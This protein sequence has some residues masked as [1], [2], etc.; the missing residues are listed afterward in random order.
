M[1]ETDE[2]HDAE[3]RTILGRDT[4]DIVCRGDAARSRHVLRRD[5]RCAR[6]VPTQMAGGEPTVII[7]TATRARADVQIDR[8]WPRLVLRAHVGT[9][10]ENSAASDQEVCRQPMRRAHYHLHSVF[11]E[12]RAGEPDC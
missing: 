12:T 1:R 8:L 6:Q 2:T 3:R 5:R 9:G 4:V 7:V 11:R 10:A